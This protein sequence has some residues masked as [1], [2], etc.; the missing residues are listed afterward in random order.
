MLL[1]GTLEICSLLPLNVHDPQCNYT[2][3][4]YDIS[5][6]ER[7]ILPFHNSYQR[8]SPLKCHNYVPQPTNLGGKPSLHPDTAG[9]E[10]WHPSCASAFAQ[11][12]IKSLPNTL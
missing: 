6:H 9:P 3:G 12:W 8:T 4:I 1:G 10:P 5:W 7:E 2:G 11:A